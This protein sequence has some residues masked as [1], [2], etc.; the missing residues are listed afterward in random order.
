MKVLIISICL[1]FSITA[2]QSE[3]RGEPA[4]AVAIEEIDRYVDQ[5][6][7][8]YGMPGV[9]LA[10]VKG[11]EVIHKKNYGYANLEHRVPV[12]DAS[13]F[14]VYSLTKPIIAVGVFQLIEQ[15][16]LSLEDQVS[17]YVSSLPAAWQP[18]QIKHLL[19]HSSGL[20]DMAPIFEFQDLTE[21][22]AKTRVFGQELKFNPGETYDYNQSNFWLLKEIIEHITEVS[23]EEFIVLNQF[24]AT[25]DTAFFSVDS[26]DIISNRATA[27][28]PFTKGEISIEHPYLQGNYAYAMNGLNITL[29]EF[30]RW[31][32]KLRANAFIKQDTKQHMWQTFPYTNS[33]KV[34]AYSWD[35]RVIN[36]KASYGFSGS[37]VTAYRIFPA[38]DMSIIF[39]SNGMGSFFDIEVV[40]NNLASIA[41]R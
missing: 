26:R 15:G 20:P 37:L 32:A 23:L 4:E 3:R 31:D 38:S 6:M 13:I 1:L 12:S 14:R 40:I 24:S 28:F 5:V 21:E 33:D 11:G 2:F 8:R 9:A 30:I 34:F 25:P 10:V 22:E 18:L 17:Q 16:K 35:K 27:Y 39:L 29:G 41:G 36:K 7:E 19:T